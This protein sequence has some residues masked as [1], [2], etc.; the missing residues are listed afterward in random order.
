MNFKFVPLEERIVLDA[1]AVTHV[2]F[3][4]AAAHSGGD[5][6]SSATAYNDLQAIMQS[7]KPIL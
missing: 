7:T 1:S 4:N 5:G 3:V 6:A 2:L